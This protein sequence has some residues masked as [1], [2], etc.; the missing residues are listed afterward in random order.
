[1]LAAGWAPPAEMGDESPFVPLA[2]RFKKDSA[3]RVVSLPCGHDAMVD[4]PKEV[5]EL[6]IEA[7]L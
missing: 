4:M 7:S 5:A 1:M 3:W 6:L 2:E